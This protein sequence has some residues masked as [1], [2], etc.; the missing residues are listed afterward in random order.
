MARE[1]ATSVA[2]ARFRPL[3]SVAPTVN[4]MT[5]TTVSTAHMAEPPKPLKSGVT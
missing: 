3:L 5:M 1:L 2:R 4:S